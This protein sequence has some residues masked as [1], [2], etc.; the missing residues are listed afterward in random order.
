MT[1]GLSM[2]REQPQTEQLVHK[3]IQRM[4]QL[5][6]QSLFIMGQGWLELSKCF[7]VP[8]TWR[9]NQGKPKMMIWIAKYWYSTA[10][11]GFTSYQLE[12]IK[13]KIITPCLPVAGYCQKIPRAVVYGPKIFGSMDWD[14]VK[15]LFLFEKSIFIIG[16][17]RL[18]D[19]VGQML[20]VQFLWVQI[21]TGI[22]TLVLQA[23]NSI[24]YLQ[25]GWV[26]ILHTHL[27]ESAVQVEVTD[28]WRPTTQR[29]DNGIFMYIVYKEIPK[30][31]W[32]GINMY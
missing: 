18:L 15:V 14:N 2:P 31:V 7:L 9:W 23:K 28:I 27:V 30:R 11:L 16:S 10:V 5:W 4:S 22:S 8:I 32:A 1:L 13:Q 24:P 12:K 19:K 21:F 3:Y 25:A 17:L 29:V 26:K 6:E 20:L